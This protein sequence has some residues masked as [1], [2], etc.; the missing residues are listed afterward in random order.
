M[1][2]IETI[3]YRAAESL[4]RLMDGADD[5]L[6]LTV[7]PPRGV[8]TRQ[9]TDIHATEDRAIMETLRFIR[10]NACNGA[11]VT[12]VA[13]QVAMSRSTLER[14]MREA[15]NRTPKQQLRYIQISKARGLLSDTSESLTEI[16]TICGFEHPEYMHVVFKREV[17]VTPGEYRRSASQ[18]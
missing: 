5:V 16:A 7:V 10:A 12:D 14:R 2:D 9:S 8:K 3:G 1:S 11:T 18:H 4:A 6:P 15:I 13:K 17:G